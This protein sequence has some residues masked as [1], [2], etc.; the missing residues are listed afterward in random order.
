MTTEVVQI[1]IRR[2]TAAEWVT[3]NPILAEGEPAKETD[4]GKIKFGDGVTA[5]NDL[6]YLVADSA[7]GG[8][9]GGTGGGGTGG[10]GVTP[11]TTGGV[12]TAS[13]ADKANET[14]TV[15]LA[16]GY[17][18]AEI[19]TSVPCRVRLYATVA[20]RDADLLRASG[21]D[22]VE[23][24]GLI[25]EFLSNTSLLGAVLSPMVDGYSLEDPP[26]P[27]IPY[28]ITN[29]SGSAAPVTVSLVWQRTE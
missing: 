18:L 17:R 9:G 11:R 25:F 22:P 2:G 27:D 5:W 15:S 10:G 28:T 8:T 23:D 3:A 29:L 1:Q 7:G 12:T 24:H 16:T 26:S 6:P 21:D 19:E 4:T 20:Q 14:G 13:L